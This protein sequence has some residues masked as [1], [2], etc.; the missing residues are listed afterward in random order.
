MDAIM[1]NEINRSQSLVKLGTG[2]KMKMM[3]TDNLLVPLTFFSII[4]RHLRR[5]LGMMNGKM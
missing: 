4:L 1:S 2:R 5:R 3:Y